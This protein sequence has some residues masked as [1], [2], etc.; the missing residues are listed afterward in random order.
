[1]YLERALEEPPEA[2]HREAVLAELGTAEAAVGSQLAAEH[3]AQAAAASPD[4]R[5]RA[6]LALRRGSAL[7][8]Q[9]THDQAAQA[10]EECMLEQANPQWIGWR[11]AAAAMCLSG[12]LERAIEITNAAL[13][14]ARRRAW[15]LA[16][17]TA[18][19]VRGLPHLWQ[20]KVS[21]GLADLELARDARRYG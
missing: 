14:D 9:G 11:M 10:Y 3:L 6:E 7:N 19:Y 13:E 18:S 16:F 15:P 17:A 12:E 20:G 4:P 5:R 21:D 1:R 2:A 8:A